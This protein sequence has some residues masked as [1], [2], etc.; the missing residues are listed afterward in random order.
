MNNLKSHRDFF[1]FSNLNIYIIGG[2]GLIGSEIVSDLIYYNAKV[3]NLDIQK[4]KKSS[5]SNHKNYNFV[6]FD[7]SHQSFKN[8]SFTNLFKKFG[9]PFILIN[10]SYPRDELW[11]KN[12]FKDISDDSFK[13]NI[14]LHLSSYALIAKNTA[15]YMIKKKING[16]ILLFSSIYGFLGQD[17]TLYQNTAMKENMT[18]S[19]I[20]SG[21][22]NLVRQMSS[23][24]GKYNLRINSISP[25]GIY[26]HEAG[27]KNIQNKNFIKNYSNKTPLNRLCYPNEVSKLVLFLIS[28]RSSYISGSNLIIDGGISIV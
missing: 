16:N 17:L 15:N 11:A 24:Y 8:S 26:G 25:G 9:D 12:N 2:S 18:Y 23:Y 20:K 21:I 5:I 7:I 1:D 3:V 13:K 19:V 10:C 14:D 6:N 27:K 22:I 4:L 28:S